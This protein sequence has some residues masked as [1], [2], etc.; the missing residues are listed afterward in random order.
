MLDIPIVQREA[1]ARCLK[2]VN[3]AKFARFVRECRL[4]RKCHGIGGCW[5][6]CVLTINI[7]GFPNSKRGILCAYGHEF[8]H[9]LDEKHKDLSDLF[10]QHALAIAEREGKGRT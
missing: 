10:D 8:K 7:A 3:L 5:N 2:C 9:W 1:W 6:T 4:P